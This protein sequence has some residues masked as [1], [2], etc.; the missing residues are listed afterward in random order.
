MGGEDD[1]CAAVHSGQLLHS[2]GVAQSVQPG[3]AALLGEGDAHKAHLTQF[4]DGLVGEFIL[5][6]QHERNGLDLLF[7]KGPDLCPQF[8]VGLSRLKQHLVTSFIYLTKIIHF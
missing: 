4:V 2:D 1:A 6:V 7:R 5:L 3:A 8:L